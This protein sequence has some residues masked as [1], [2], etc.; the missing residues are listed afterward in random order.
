MTL[1]ATLVPEERPLA[2]VVRAAAFELIPLAS[3]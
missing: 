3:V 1:D 2:R